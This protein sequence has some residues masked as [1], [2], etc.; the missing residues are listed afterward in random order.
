MPRRLPGRKRRPNPAGRKKA[1][2]A[3]SGFLVGKSD[4]VY[5]A[6]TKAKKRRV[7]LAKGL[8]RA[9]RLVQEV[10]LAEE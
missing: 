2:E 5:N 7:V 3:L 10:R 1:E 6:L 8:Q 4:S 9:L